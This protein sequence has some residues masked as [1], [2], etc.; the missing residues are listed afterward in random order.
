[1]K[2]NWQ[3]KKLGELITYERGLTYAKSNE[4]NYSNNIVLRA[5]NINLIS[6]KLDLTDLKYIDDGII[7]PP[8]KKINTGSIL[9]CTASGSKNHLGKVAFIEKKYN[10]AYGGFMALIHPK[11][12]IDS[13]YLYYNLVS[14]KY[15]SFINKLA[16]ALN[17]NNLK[18][19]TLK[20]FEISFPQLT[21][22]KRIV[23]ILDEA[24]E[25][26]EK[27]KMN[28]EKNVQNAKE[29]F[30]A[31]LNT[32]F[33]A[34]RNTWEN[35][36]LNEIA[37]TEKNQKKNT[38][39]PYVGMEDIESGT[40]AF[41][42]S[43]IPHKV[44][45]STFH[46]NSKHILYGRLRPYLNKVLLPDFEGHCSTEIFPIRVNNLVMKKLLFYWFLSSESVKKI[47]NTTTG[48]RMPRANMKEVFN[49]V[50]Q[51]PSSMS[52]QQ[53]VVNKLDNLFEEAI[54]LGKTYEQK[55]VLLEE[56]KKS[57]LHKAFS[58]EL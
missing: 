50:I 10:F 27:A 58:G 22:Q 49:F 33:Y 39:L 38:N 57:I 31:Y 37:V 35:K 25:K 15:R 3:T 47:N 9:I 52:D 43:D 34:K 21:E 48:A 53:A 2:H 4:V 51:Y 32:I 1:M 18:Y 55:I 46:F 16:D 7:I 26:I 20:D 29:F 17:I 56:L 54:Q 30:E 28:T 11:N 6:N 45:S 42:G 13:K 36:P 19:D 5:N 23:S 14:D 41:L 40:G 8:K 12:D 24:F 44:K